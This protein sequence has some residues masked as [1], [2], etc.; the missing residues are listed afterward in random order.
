MNNRIGIAQFHVVLDLAEWH[1]KLGDL[2]EDKIAF[3]MLETP[4][5][6]EF[7]RDNIYSDLMGGMAN[8]N[9]PVKKALFAILNEQARY[10]V[11]PLMAT[12][13]AV[14]R[15]EYELEDDGV[16]AWG[17]NITDWNVMTRAEFDNAIKAVLP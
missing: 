15:Y 7:F 17:L 2:D 13:V 10:R 14:F 4:D 3:S 6:F 11:S 12:V 5:F 16:H 1:G 9:A 8:Q